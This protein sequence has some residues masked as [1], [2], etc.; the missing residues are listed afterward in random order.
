MAHST[1]PFDFNVDYLASV[2]MGRGYG[3]YVSLLRPAVMAEI[4][5]EYHLAA[6]IS[7]YYYPPLTAQIIMPFTLLPPGPAGYIWMGLTALALMAAAWILGKTLARPYATS[8]ALLVV[9]FFYP[10]HQT[11]AAG[12]INGL[13]LLALCCAFY[14]AGRQDE[15]GLGTGVAVAAMLKIVPLAHLAYL[16]WQRNWKAFAAGA[17]A[18]ALLFVSAVPITGWKAITDFISV[19]LTI[20]AAAGPGAG[21]VVKNLALSGM[22]GYVAGS[23]A[24]SRTLWLSAVGAIIG[25]TAVACWPTT[26]RR[27]LFEVEFS[28]VTLT[29]NLVTPYAFYHQF[30]LMVIPLFVVTKHLVTTPGR[31]RLVGLVIAA[32]GLVNL[33][34]YGAYLVRVGLWL[35]A[36]APTYISLILWGL[37]GLWLVRLKFGH[38]RERPPGLAHTPAGT[39]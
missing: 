10:A 19:F 22:I 4:A 39:A 8:L 20:G 1:E 33:A 6:Y 16:G 15:I 34:M 14:A 24:A 25:L 27:E 5:G 2:A 11:V 21:Q 31:R 37:M 9:M 18:V 29:A 32:Y 12:Q 13:M 38:V 17:V 30:V 36:F 26:R 7:P 23:G 3:P 28:M 35:V